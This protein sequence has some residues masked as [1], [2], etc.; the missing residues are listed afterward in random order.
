[1]LD[2]DNTLVLKLAQAEVD[3]LPRTQGGSVGYEANKS[4][5]S[6]QPNAYTQGGRV[7]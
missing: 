1:M 7:D 5:V 6:Y 3:T 2:M 4:R